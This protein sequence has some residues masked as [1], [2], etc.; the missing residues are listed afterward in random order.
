MTEL[1]QRVGK[2]DGDANQK[3]CPACNLGLD[4]RYPSG[5]AVTM[6]AAWVCKDGAARLT[7]LARLG[8]R[9]LISAV[10]PGPALGSRAAW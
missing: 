6:Q 9:V 7:K 2:V 8:L 10:K 3:R 1:F 5:A 4:C